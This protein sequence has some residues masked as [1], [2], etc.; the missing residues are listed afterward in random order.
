MSYPAVAAK[1][2]QYFQCDDVGGTRYLA[3]DYTIDCGSDYYE[4]WRVVAIVCT[5]VYVCGFPLSLLVSVGYM[6]LKKGK[7][8]KKITQTTPYQLQVR[9]PP[10]LSHSPKDV[11]KTRRLSKE[12]TK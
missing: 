8:G 7:R 2:L 12:A 4:S 9:R 5:I 3:A 10:L 1:A 6:H 11:K